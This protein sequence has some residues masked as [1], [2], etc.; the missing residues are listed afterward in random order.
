MEQVVG[1]TI[2]TKEKTKKSTAIFYSFG[3]VGN[4]LSWYMIN[5]YLMIFYTDIVG[6]AAGAIS[7]IM[8]IARLWQAINGP[9]WGMVQDRTYTKWGKFRPYLMSTE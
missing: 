3:E 9:V 1:K 5:T 4:Q 2:E 7:I 8:L 6:M